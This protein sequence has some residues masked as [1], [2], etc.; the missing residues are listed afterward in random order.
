MLVFF[1]RVPYMQLSHIIPGVNINGEKVS[2]AN[3][4]GAGRS[5]GV[6][7]SHDELLGGRAS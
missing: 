1:N 2:I 7:R 6:L 5:G 3:V 4:N